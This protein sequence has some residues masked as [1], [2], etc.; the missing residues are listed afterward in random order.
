MSFDKS[1]VV[2]PSDDKQLV[3][4]TS[5]WGRLFSSCVPDE[6]GPVKE[7]KCKFPFINKDKTLFGCSTSRTPSKK[8]KDCNKM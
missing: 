2:G 5:G 3:V 1:D 7:L 4:Y 8:D 6:F